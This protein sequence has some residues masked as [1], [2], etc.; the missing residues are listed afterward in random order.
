V[1]LSCVNSFNILRQF[2]FLQLVDPLL[3]SVCVWVFYIDYVYVH[4]YIHVHMYIWKYTKP[5]AVLF[6]LHNRI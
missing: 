4:A 3:V 1:F 6:L 5:I 2:F